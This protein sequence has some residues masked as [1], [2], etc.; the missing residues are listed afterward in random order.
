M[1]YKH[2]LPLNGDFHSFAHGQFS[3]IEYFWKPFSCW[4]ST[5]LGKERIH[6]KMKNLENN[7]YE[8]ACAFHA[9]QTIAIV[10]YLILNVKTPA[11][12]L[13]LQ[14]PQLYLAMLRSAG[15]IVIF[16]YLL[17]V[18]FPMLQVG[19]STCNYFAPRTA[20]GSRAFRS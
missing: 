4:A 9:E 2:C 5:V 16:R 12:T 17:H 3:G 13:L 20:H 8:H 6:E 19:Q 7:N 15:G 10:Q 1:R 18:G 11:P 14:N